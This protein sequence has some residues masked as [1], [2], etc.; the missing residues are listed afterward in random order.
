M[1]YFFV[2]TV[3][4][5]LL[6]GCATIKPDPK[7]WTTTDKI[8][9]GFFLA[10]H[11]ADTYTTIRHQDYPDKIYEKNPILGKHP[12]DHEIYLYMGATAAIG[13]IAAHYFPKLRLPICIGYGGVGFYMAW[14]NYKKIREVR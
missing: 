7:P 13:L 12:D 4:S 14:G 5:F 8:G 10:G 2:V 9:A 6:S 1:K 11:M 3:L